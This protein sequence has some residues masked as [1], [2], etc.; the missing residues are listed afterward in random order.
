MNIIVDQRQIPKPLTNSM[1]FKT[2]NSMNI[3]VTEH[4]SEVPKVVNVAPQPTDIPSTFAFILLFLKV[5]LPMAVG[6]SCV[7]LHR[8]VRLHG[9][10]END[11]MEGFDKARQVECIV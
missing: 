4:A 6:S 5:K 11:K 3:S 8:S 7:Q 1:I 10:R 2:S 9:E